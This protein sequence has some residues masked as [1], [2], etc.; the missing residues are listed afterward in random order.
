MDVE[1]TP[2]DLTLL[3]DALDDAIRAARM[4]QATYGYDKRVFIADV[5]AL[6][7]KLTGH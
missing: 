6:R 2:D 4:E 3:R 1:L 5:K 7:K